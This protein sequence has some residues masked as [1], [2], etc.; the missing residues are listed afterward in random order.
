MYLSEPCFTSIICAMESCVYLDPLYVKDYF[1]QMHW[2][3]CFIY[4][5]KFCLSP[6]ISVVQKRSWGSRDAKGILAIIH[7]TLSVKVN[8]LLNLSMLFW[9]ET[10]SRYIFK[11]N[12]SRK[13]SGFLFKHLDMSFHYQNNQWGTIIVYNY[14]LP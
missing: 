13:K 3:W 11:S 6:V 7:L 14:C 2:Q 12:S 8:L 9:Q 1:V 5:T 4:F 10:T